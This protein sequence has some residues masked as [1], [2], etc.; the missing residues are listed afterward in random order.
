MVQFTEKV[1]DA[2][3]FTQLKIND[4][5]WATI[6]QAHGGQTISVRATRKGVYPFVELISDHVTIDEIKTKLLIDT[7]MA[8]SKIFED[9]N[10]FKA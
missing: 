6:Y 2:G 3:T 7:K 8:L 10:R 4:I 1:T 9:I 5:T